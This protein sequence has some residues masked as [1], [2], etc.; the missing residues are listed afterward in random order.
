ID[1]SPQRDAG[2]RTCDAHLYSGDRSEAALCYGSLVSSSQDARIRAEASWSLG[3]LQTANSYFQTAIEIYP[4]DAHAR[5]RWGYLFIATHQDNDAVKLFQEALELEPELADA[6]LGIA[7]VAAGR[8]EER[9]NELVDQVIESHPERLDGYLLKARMSL[10]EGNLGEADELL[11][12]ALE[13]VE[14][15]DVVPLELYALYAARDLLHDVVDSPWTG[16][17]LEYNPGYGDIYAIPAHFYVITRRYRQAIELYERAVETQPNLWSAH[18][19]LGVNLLRENRI[20]DA[21]RH[22]QI[23]YGG[24]PFSAQIVNTLR[25]IDSFDNF[26]V[27]ERLAEE[28][29]NAP[30]PGMI[31]RLHND[32]AAVLDP[33]V[34]DLVNDSIATFSERYQFD[35]GEPVIVELY[36]EHDDFAVR[37]SGLPGIGL[38]GVTFGYLVAMDSPTGRAEGDFHWGTTLWHEMAHVF[39]LEATAHLVPRWYSEGISVYEEWSTGPLPGRHIPLHV[40]QA[41]EEDKLL[42]IL[43]LDSGF[44]R[45]TYEGQVMVSYMQAGLICQYIADRWGQQGLVDVLNGFGDGLT[46]AEVLQPAL[47]ISA[48]DFD[49]GFDDFLQ[50]ELGATLASLPA[51]QDELRSAIESLS[52]ESWQKAI[53]AADRAIVSY[54][55]H[56]AENS[57]YLVKARAHDE[58]GQIDLATDALEQYWRR[59]GY[60]PTALKR[61]AGWLA[62]ADRTADSVSVLSDALWVSPLDDALHV[63]LGGWLLAEEMP[64]LALREFEASLAMNPYDQA[65]AYYRLATAYQQLGDDARTLEHLLYALEIAPHYR[66]AQQLLLEIAR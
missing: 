49:R 64:E 20:D 8:F 59:G 9:A 43:E 12:D 23:A 55:G 33:Y 36:P 19:E 50:R 52:E 34:T 58:L 53:E 11:A 38:L 48:S 60:E 14:R 28:G 7:S 15:T 24:D 54:P 41:I 4:D 44:I 35:L 31:L 47:G 66:E 42:P 56:V 63:Q 6:M 10:E 13:V 37:T 16:R 2:L 45:P 1:Y 51:W 40:L 17:A 46:T 62:E 57:A 61:L 5:A 3:D 27:I 32:E 21:Q 25:L 22:L 18:A 39:T 26:Q 29:E 65:A 30:H